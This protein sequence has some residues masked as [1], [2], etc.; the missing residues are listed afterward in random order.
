M[1]VINIQM[2][3]FAAFMIYIYIY[4]TTLY[5]S[6]YDVIDIITIFIHGILFKR[7]IDNEGT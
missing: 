2:R 3:N 4:P 7:P 5:R 1:M 6:S